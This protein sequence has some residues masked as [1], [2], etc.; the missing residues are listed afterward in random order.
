[1]SG[2]HGEESIMGGLPRPGKALKGVLLTL[3]ALWLMFAV[4]VNWAGASED[5]FY[6]FCGSTERILSGE[7]W[8]LFTAPLMHI[9]QGTIG[10]ILSALIGLYFLA[11]SLEA[12]WGSGRFLRFLIMSA[13]FAYVLQMV[14]ELVLPA[15][16]SGRLVG[17]YWYGAIPVVEAVAIA[18]ALSFKGR[19]VRLMFVLPVS[20]RGLIIFVIAISVMYLIADAQTPA[21]HI[22]PFGGMIAGWLFG[23]GTPSPMRRFYLKWRLLQLDTEARRGRQERRRRVERS[24]LKV[25]RGGNAPDEADND[26]A[27]NGNSNGKGPRGPDGRLL[28]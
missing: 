28:D 5:V 6:L 15:S 25:I 1:M 21:G 27:G 7:V 22:A 2:R 18:W 23:G 24:K 16:M 10:H 12:Q 9:P 17:K 11:P 14:L 20:S 8:R 26:G 3:F 19:I 4:A 13:L